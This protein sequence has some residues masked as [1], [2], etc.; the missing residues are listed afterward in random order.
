MIWSVT[1]SYVC[2]FVCLSVCL[3]VCLWKH[4]NE[5]DLCC[6]ENYE[7]AETEIKVKYLFLMKLII[8]FL[9]ENVTQ[10]VFF[11]YRKFCW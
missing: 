1:S 11:G 4:R 10:T 5:E 9:K 3:S 8:L 7:I 6:T 2:V